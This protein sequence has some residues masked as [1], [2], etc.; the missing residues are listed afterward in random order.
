MKAPSPVSLGPPVT[1]R[2]WQE[3]VA[4][5]EPQGGGV[6]QVGRGP[7]AGHPPRIIVTP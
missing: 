3:H 4:Y 7:R 1:T 6:C 2:T 5:V